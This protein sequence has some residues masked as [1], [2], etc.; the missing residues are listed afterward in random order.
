MKVVDKNFLEIFENILPAGTKNNKLPA[1]NDRGF[2]FTGSIRAGKMEQKQ[3]WNSKQLQKQGNE[4]YVT[5]T[6]FWRH[7]LGRTAK[8]LRWMCAIVMDFDTKNGKIDKYEL[9]L[10]IADAGLPPASAFV[11]SPSGGA[12]IWWFLRPV[13]ATPKA[14]RL[15]TTLQASMAAELGAD[16]GAIG[17]ERFW[18]LPTAGNVIY[19]SKRKYKL[20][21]FKNWRDKNRPQD[22]PGPARG[23]QVYAFTRGLLAHPGIKQLMQG[24]SRGFRNEACFSVAVA[25]LITGFS[26]PETLQILFSWNQ[27]NLPPMPEREVRK[28]VGSAAKGLQKNRLH[29]HNAMRFKIRNL[30]GTEIKYRPVTPPKPRQ[31]RKRSHIKEWKQDILSLLQKRGDRI[32]ITQSRLAETLGAP[33]RS[34][35]LALAQL[36]K[37]GKIFLDAVMRG[38]KSFTIIIS[39]ITHK[40]KKQMVHSGTH[41]GEQG[42]S[43][44]LENDSP[45]PPEPS[46]SGACLLL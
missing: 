41:Y 39:K 35:K 29:Y 23:G 40:C 24:V 20:S 9:A 7:N 2:I 15:F 44:N 11:R 12:H 30:T 17:A 43:W 14:V 26:V 6:A 13:R 32:L 16:M 42:I 21:I 3:A 38:R 45:L 37:E 31:Q 1:E 5:A 33:L 4:Q 36:E 19:S 28:C 27:K 25:H 34:I 22:A 46:Y 10:K 18:R 8:N